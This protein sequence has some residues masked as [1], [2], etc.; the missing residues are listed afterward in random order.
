MAVDVSET[1]VQS[2]RIDDPDNKEAWQYMR[3]QPLPT[4]QTTQLLEFL[5]IVLFSVA[6]VL[7]SGTYGFATEVMTCGQRVAHQC[8]V[9]GRRH[10][11]MYGWSELRSV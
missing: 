4:D 6:P 9:F 2:D 3:S 10:E 5:A 11:R 8:T 7:I 1:V